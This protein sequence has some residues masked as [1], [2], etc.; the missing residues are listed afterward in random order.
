MKHNLCFRKQGAV[1]PLCQRGEVKDQSTLSPADTSPT[2]TS[3][4]SNQP[5][6]CPAGWSEFG[7]SCY[8][9]LEDWLNWLDAGASCQHLDP[10]A[11]L[12]SSGSLQEDGFLEDLVLEQVGN[13]WL[14]GTDAGEEGS[15]VWSDGSHFSFTNWGPGEGQDGPQHNCLAMNTNGDDWNDLACWATLWAVCEVSMA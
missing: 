9:V 2:T 7:G 3:T 13:V 12:A 5:P 14:G 15:W 4:T 8:W 11:H 10:L 1:F 6:S